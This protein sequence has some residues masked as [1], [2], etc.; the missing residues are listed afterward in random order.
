MRHSGGP[1]QKALESCQGQKRAKT[2]HLP[3]PHA[4][5]PPRMGIKE[6]QKE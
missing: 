3:F 2:P 1:L 6:K 5:Q 4:W